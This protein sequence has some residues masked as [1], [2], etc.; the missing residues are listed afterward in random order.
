MQKIIL[1]STSPRRKQILSAMGLDFDIVSPPFKESALD[2]KF[3]YE[4]IESIAENKALSVSQIIKDKEKIII[5][6]DTVVVFDDRVL[7]KP[8]DY[9]DSFNMLSSLNGMEHIVVTSVCVINKANGN[10]IVRSETS[11][12][13]FNCV[14]KL[15]IA[16]YI[17]NYKPYDKA[18]SYGIQELPENF[19]C[20]TEGDYNNIVGLP[21]KLLSEI[22]KEITE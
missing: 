4:L 6:A 17:V 14:S 21:D 12:V 5:G 7:G 9:E 16:N 2:K 18:G 1:A 8:K 20:E 11:K 22:L 15:E 10:K 19:I 3:S 13:R